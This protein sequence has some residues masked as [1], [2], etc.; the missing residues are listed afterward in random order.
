MSFGWN[1]IGFVV[2]GGG[3]V[4][5]FHWSR[6]LAVFRCSYHSGF[7]GNVVSAAEVGRG[8]FVG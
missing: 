2:L 8:R 5:I 3:G 4:D 6:E 7:N 1:C